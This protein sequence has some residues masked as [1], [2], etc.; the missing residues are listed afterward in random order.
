MSLVDKYIDCPNCKSEDCFETY[1]IGTGETQTRC[2]LCGYHH[3]LTFKRD[4]NGILVRSIETIGEVPANLILAEIKI[5]K[6]YGAFS[7]R[8]KGDIAYSCGTL[9]TVEDYDKLAQHVRESNNG[10]DIAK[11]R[12]FVDGKFEIVDIL[13]SITGVKSLTDGDDTGKD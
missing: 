1:N 3:S 11:V 8:A 5:D 6:P 4:A 12:R 9:G 13:E 2:P 10:F 7:L